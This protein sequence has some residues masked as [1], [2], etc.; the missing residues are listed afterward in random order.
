MSD[1]SPTHKIDRDQLAADIAAIHEQITVDATP[2]ADLRHLRK[3]EWWGRICTLLGYATAWMI[4]NPVS[5]LL[6]S[7]G[8]FTRWAL[9]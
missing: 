5:A 6:I 9:I 2:D 1:I 7:Q 3:M 8:I 4:P